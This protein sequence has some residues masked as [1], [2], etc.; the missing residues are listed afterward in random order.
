MNLFRRSSKP[1]NS[2]IPAYTPATPPSPVQNGSARDSGEGT[3]APTY[4]SQPTET[5]SQ[6]NFKKYAVVIAIDF[7]TTFSV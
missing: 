3:S 5:E 1:S 2:S 4:A 6:S 7:G